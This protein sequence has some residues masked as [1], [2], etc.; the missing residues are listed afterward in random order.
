MSLLRPEAS[1]TASLATVGL[2]YG[3]YQITLPNVTDVRAAP[4]V[5]GHI[6]KSERV[7]TWTAAA[8]VSGTAL[9]ARDMNIFILGGA[10]TVAF[11]WYYKHANHVNPLTTVAGAFRNSAGVS[12]MGPT[13][14]MMGAAGYGQPEVSPD[15]YAF[16]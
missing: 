12:S 13:D 8:F 9:I 11:A 15:S 6:A 16:G 4:P 7:A 14:P 5:D 2:V 1:I 3:I 10:A